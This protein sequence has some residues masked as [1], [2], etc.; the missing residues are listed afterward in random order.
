MEDDARW[1]AEAVGGNREAHRTLFER[2]RSAVAR[3]A[4]GFA[5][6]DEDEVQDVVQESFVRAFSSLKGLREPARFGPWVL[7]IARNRSLSHL[8]RKQVQ[9]KALNEFE[10]EVDVE[11]AQDPGPNDAEINVVRLLID[12][13]KDGPEK[14]T[15][16]LFY[17]E[18][19]LSAREIAERMGVGKSAVTMRL[20]RFRAKVK[21]HLAAKI[22]ELRGDDEGGDQDAA[23]RVKRAAESKD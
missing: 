7:T 21:A 5:D 3:V 13:L 10:A 9:Q 19:K 4:R 17:V 12:G 1:V 23:A 11:L 15:V 18:G 6:L 20:E 8:S 14:E 16:R 22:L 2:Y